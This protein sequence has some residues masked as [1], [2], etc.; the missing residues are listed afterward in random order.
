MICWNHWTPE[1]DLTIEFGYEIKISDYN[2]K[3]FSL[4]FVCYFF[5]LILEIDKIQ[6]YACELNLELTVIF[7]VLLRLNTKSD[8]EIIK[9][10]A[11]FVLTIVFFVFLGITYTSSY[12]LTQIWN[13][14]C[15]IAILNTCKLMSSRI[16]EWIACNKETV[17]IIWGVFDFNWCICLSKVKQIQNI[18]NPK[19]DKL[20]IISFRYDSCQAESNESKYS[21]NSFFNYS[22]FS[23]E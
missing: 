10:D 12:I 21:V 9:P 19:V 22:F 15:F 18:S 2:S 14:C 17:Y 5:R 3:I 4:M 1:L 6:S 8:C 7:R 11:L 23:Y 13:D 20:F 16:F